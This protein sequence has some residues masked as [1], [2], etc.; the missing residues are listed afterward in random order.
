MVGDHSPQNGINSRKKIL[1]IAGSDPTAGAGLQADLK[2]VTALGGYAMTVAT[3]ITVQ[4]TTEVKKVHPLPG[5]LVAEQM[6]ACL[7]DIGVDAIK[8]GMLAT[9]EIVQAVAKELRAY[10]NIPV[11]ADPVL[12][13]TGG[14]RLLDGPGRRVFMEQLLPRISLLTPNCPE[15]AA[16][17]GMR[18]QSQ[19]EQESVAKTLAA[20]GCNILLTGGHLSG[21]T[22]T[23]ILVD[24]T[25]IAYKFFSKRL[26]G[27]S[28]HGTGC[29]LATAITVNMAYGLPLHKAVT[30]ALAYLKRAM[31]G[32]LALGQGQRLLH[33]KY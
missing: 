5:D 33:S 3:A 9:A 4:N 19:Q 7:G 17:S 6:A 16:L 10:P 21:A 12:A 28:F 22:I 25:G 32:S 24:T 30:A 1:I 2:T 27:A 18:V 23:D 29:T 14:G 31:H 13:G 8:I 11:V 20:S 26:T 15:A